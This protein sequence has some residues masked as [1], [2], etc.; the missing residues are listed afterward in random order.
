VDITK[1]ELQQLKNALDFMED[2]ITDVVGWANKPNDKIMA[3]HECK[4]IHELAVELIYDIWNRRD[5]T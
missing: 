3:M 2:A 1:D 5:K 4:K